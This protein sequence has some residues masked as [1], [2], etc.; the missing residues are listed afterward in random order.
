MSAENYE[1]FSSE[2]EQKGV[3]SE[4]FIVSDFTGE[5]AE[6]VARAA[7]R[8][9]DRH[10]VALRRFRTVDT[11]DKALN[12]CWLAKES[13]ALIVCTL[14]SQP[15]REA[16][17]S[18]AADLGLKVVDLFGPIL[19]AISEKL[20]EQPSGTPGNRHKLDEAYF[21]RVKAIEF[22]STCDDGANPNL[23]PEAELVIVGV[24]RT[25]KTPLSMYLAN[26]G[27]RTAN[28]PLVPELTPPD[29]LFTLPAGRVLGLSIQP[30]VLQK[31]RRDRL[32]MIGLNPEK[33]SYAQMTR[34]EE[35]L[36]YA[37]NIMKRLNARVVDVTGRA[38]EE[39]AQEVLDYL[40]EQ[41]CPAVMD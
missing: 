30:A 22:S 21:R 25:C 18:L 26:K 8:Q 23:L 31:I 28:V 32:A 17:T 35:E 5:T 12:V 19:S 37:K 38:L 7:L 15:V 9:F 16:L 27:V 13:S 41:G 3:K 29:E 4:I 39:T 34:V 10:C 40:R 20:G 2:A 33:A 6:T 11:V 14:V 36:A 1:L 24:S